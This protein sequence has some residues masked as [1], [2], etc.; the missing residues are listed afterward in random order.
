M[1]TKSETIPQE[2]RC[3]I[4]LQSQCINFFNWPSDD[5]SNACY[6]RNALTFKDTTGSEQHSKRKASLVRR[7]EYASIIAETGSDDMMYSLL[8]C[9]EEPEAIPSSQGSQRFPFPEDPTIEAVGEALTSA[10]KNVQDI[11]SPT[12]F[13]EQPEKTGSESEPTSS[14]EEN[15]RTVDIIIV[16]TVLTLP[17]RQKLLTSLMQKNNDVRLVHS[18]AAALTG[19]F[20]STNAG[21]ALLASNLGSLRLLALE[22]A[23]EYISASIVTVDVTLDMNS[24][25][26]QRTYE[27]IIRSR[28]I[29]K[30]STE[31][32]QTAKNVHFGEAQVVDSNAAEKP[33]KVMYDFR[34]GRDWDDAIQPSHAYHKDIP[35][36]P[37]HSSGWKGS[38]TSISV[39]ASEG[40]TA[41]GYKDLDVQLIQDWLSVLHHLQTFTSIS[42]WNSTVD[43]REGLEAWT[44]RITK[45]NRMLCL[46]AIRFY[47]KN[48]KITSEEAPEDGFST[49]VEEK[50][51]QVEM[52]SDFN[53]AFGQYEREIDRVAL[54]HLYLQHFCQSVLQTLPSW[55]MTQSMTILEMLLRQYAQDIIYVEAKPENGEGVGKFWIC[56]G[57][58]YDRS[59]S[60]ESGEVNTDGS[61]LPAEERIVSHARR[62]WKNAV[63]DIVEKCAVKYSK[64]LD[65]RCEL[66]FNDRAPLPVYDALI[67]WQEIPGENDNLSLIGNL[68]QALHIFKECPEKRW[69]WANNSSGYITPKTAIRLQRENVFNLSVKAVNMG[70]N[71]LAR[72]CFHNPLTVEN[73]VEESPRL[74]SERLGQSWRITENFST[75]SAGGVI[76]LAVVPGKLFREHASE[77]R[78]DLLTS[79]KHPIIQ[80]IVWLHPPNPSPSHYIPD[81]VTRAT[82]YS[83]H[84][85]TTAAQKMVHGEEINL[86]LHRELINDN[87]K[88]KSAI[89]VMPCACQEIDYEHARRQALTCL[90]DTSSDEGKL[91]FYCVNSGS[92]LDS[93]TSSRSSWDS[94]LYDLVEASVDGTESIIGQC[95]VSVN[96]SSQKD[97]PDDDLILVLLWKRVHSA[98]HSSQRDNAIHVLGGLPLSESAGVDKEEYRLL[99]LAHESSGLLKT[100]INAVVPWVEFEDNHLKTQSAKQTPLLGNGQLNKFSLLIY[101]W[102]LL[103]ALLAIVAQL[104]FPKSQHVMFEQTATLHSIKPVMQESVPLII[105]NSNSWMKHEQL[106]VID[107]SSN[108][109]SGE[110]IVRSDIPDSISMNVEDPLVLHE[111]VMRQVSPRIDLGKTVTAARTRITQIVSK[112]SSDVKQ[113]VVMVSHSTS[114]SSKHVVKTIK[115]GYQKIT[116]A[117][118]LAAWAI[119]LIVQD[120]WFS[121]VE[122]T[123]LSGSKLLGTA[124]NIGKRMRSVGRFFAKVIQKK[125]NEVV[126]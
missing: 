121:I 86:V 75:S 25:I 92:T 60:S 112:L 10:W 65:E 107:Q 79:A 63:I 44:H 47:R 28:P 85:H 13:E 90:E 72:H 69:K 97:R 66:G 78:A 34:A 35:L 68:D 74:R 5:R 31:K 119:S 106:I 3:G 8:R 20:L 41:F 113:K 26:T 103:V 32:G 124:K 54:L 46:E 82:R 58:D 17:A 57:V 39:E 105:D 126:V 36:P 102:L 30:Y 64:L 23:E 53:T 116:K 83:P 56:C 19:A 14:E 70:A 42:D 109:T 110:R 114:S 96:Q 120:K 50:A 123:L 108:E 104:F 27:E 59:N 115:V 6:Y 81:E 118:Q 122:E 21:S 80:H 40:S 100:D 67:I 84:P 111:L 87:Q 12:S 9:L 62:S 18:S 77:I 89:T 29:L 55:I 48:W 22:L 16:P 45:T 7:E 95:M 49:S 93:S 15:K 51:V 11:T 37:A 71:I 94:D 43:I 33:M 73:K 117:V 4:V 125:R 76:G 88:I 98:L 91:R 1:T 2:P 24:Q 61:D 38:A 101:A 52:L 99:R